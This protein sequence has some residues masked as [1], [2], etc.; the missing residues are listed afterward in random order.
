[1]AATCRLPGDRSNTERSCKSEQE[2]KE[3]KVPGEGWDLIKDGTQ[4][5]KGGLS[6]HS[7]AVLVDILRLSHLKCRRWG[8][9]GKGKGRERWAGLRKIEEHLYEARYGGIH[10]QSSPGRQVQAYLEFEASLDYTANLCLKKH[11]RKGVGKE[12]FCRFL[13]NAKLLGCRCWEGRTSISFRAGS[14]AGQ[15]L[16]GSKIVPFRVLARNWLKQWTTNCKPGKWEVGSGDRGV[17]STEG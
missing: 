8:H 3:G 7:T 4:K 17:G 1:M 16:P 9:S 10:L 5:A 13:T 12:Y 11:H 14:L 6:R 15:G 2:D